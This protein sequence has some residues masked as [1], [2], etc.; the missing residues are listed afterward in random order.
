[1][2]AYS[3]MLHAAPELS[4]KTGLHQCWLRKWLTQQAGMGVL[5]LLPG[6]ADDDDFYNI[7][8]PLPRC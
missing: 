8:Y 5:R 1:M 7:G 6:K 4:E 3:V 2:I